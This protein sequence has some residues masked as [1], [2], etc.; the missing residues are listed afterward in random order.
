MPSSPPRVSQKIEPNSPQPPPPM[1][2]PDDDRPRRGPLLFR[3][4][5]RQ[6]QP[7]LP[8]RR[9]KMVVVRLGDRRGWRSGR[10]ILVGFL[11]RVQLRW[12]VGQYR[13]ALKRVT[14]CY[15]ALMRDLIDGAA[16]METV[17]SQ[18]LME[19]YFTVPMVPITVAN[20]A[21]YYKV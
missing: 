18:M 9:R 12:L 21:N 4:P 1:A 16:T 17:R 13:K 14:A 19:S 6:F 8:S 10:R 11:R 5:R 7:A 3:L 20:C 15:V 2:A